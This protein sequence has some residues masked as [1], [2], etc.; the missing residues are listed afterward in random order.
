MKVFCPNS[1]C[2]PPILKQ[3]NRSIQK[4][5]IGWLALNGFR[6]KKAL[7][8]SLP[9]LHAKAFVQKEPVRGLHVDP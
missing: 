5:S 4:I 8:G 6:K 1:R 9:I 7:R 3:F 2:R